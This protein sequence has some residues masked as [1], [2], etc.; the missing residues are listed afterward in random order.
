MTLMSSDRWRVRFTVR[1]LIYCLKQ[2]GAVSNP[3]ICKALPMFLQRCGRRLKQRGKADAGKK[4]PCARLLYIRCGR[5]TCE[6]QRRIPLRY[7]KF[8]GQSLAGCYRGLWSLPA[9]WWLPRGRASFLE[10]RSRLV[11]YLMRAP[12]TGQ[13][14][15]LCHC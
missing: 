5:I 15:N 3:W 7:L 8:S 1:H 2:S 10:E 6:R 9:I 12:K 13:L 4:K 14:M 11:S